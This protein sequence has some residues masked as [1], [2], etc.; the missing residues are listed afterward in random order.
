[1]DPGSALILQPNSISDSALSTNVALKNSSNTFTQQ[2][3]FN[4]LLQ[5]NKPAGQTG[6]Q[7]YDSTNL[8][9]GNIYLNNQLWNFVTNSNNTHYY[10]K[11]NDGTGTQHTLLDL[12]YAGPAFDCS[13][14]ITQTATMPAANDSSTKT[15]TTQWVQTA[16]TASIP[17][18]IAILANNQTFTGQN[19][20]N[21]LVNISKTAGQNGFQITDS[22][23]STNTT[24]TLNNN[25]ST[26]ATSATNGNH[27]F[28]VKDTLG[29]LQTALT[30]NYTTP[31]LTCSGVLT[32]S[33]TMPASNDSSTK[34]PTTAWVQ[35]AITGASGVFVL[36]NNNTATGQNIFTSSVANI[37]LKIQST[38]SPNYQGCHF[39]ANGGGQ[40]NN[41]VAANEYVVFG[42]NSATLGAGTLTLTNHSATSVGMKITGTNTVLYGPPLQINQTYNVIPT[43]ID[44]MGYQNKFTQATMNPWTTN[45]STVLCQW[46]PF[47]QTGSFPYG[48]Y[49]FQAKIVIQAGTVQLTG[50]IGTNNAVNITNDAV[51]FTN[52]GFTIGANNYALINMNVTLNIFS[53]VTYYVTAQQAVGA[54]TFHTSSYATLTRVC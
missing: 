33:A 41:I 18:G 34:V 30:L 23:N 29:T 8:V 27:I 45:V 5:I 6:F 35:S 51:S 12:T 42:D 50:S 19:T 3:T 38:S 46:G 10:F 36:A 26:I 9:S 31:S 48:T 17:T 54:F 22:T 32:Q 7:I 24:I 25:N 4:N 2:N 47:A 53:P 43:A 44:Q 40:Y 52:Q 1:M 16:I 11:G 49:N 21:N 28:Q 37:P 20:F 15:P 39:V 14:P 13:S